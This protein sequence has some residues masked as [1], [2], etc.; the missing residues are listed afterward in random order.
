LVNIF[1]QLHDLATAWFIGSE[2][3]QLPWQMC[4]FFFFI[5]ISDAVVALIDAAALHQLMKAGLRRF[6]F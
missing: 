3:A 2:N 5:H 1:L 6:L 4:F